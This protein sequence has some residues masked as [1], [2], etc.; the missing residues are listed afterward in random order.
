MTTNAQTSVSDVESSVDYSALI[1]AT[2]ELAT[3]MGIDA[4]PSRGSSWPIDVGQRSITAD[5][6]GATSGRIYLS[7]ADDDVQRLLDDPDGAADVVRDLVAAVGISPEEVS[8]APLRPSDDL[9]SVHVVARSDDRIVAFGVTIDPD[10]ALAGSANQSMASSFEPS[11]LSATGTTAG[12]AGTM[13][14]PISLLSDVDMQVTVE[15]GRTKLPVRELLSLQP[16]MVVELDRQAGEPIDVLVNGR[17]L[18]RG[19]VVVL[20]EQF[21]L[22]I[23]EIVSATTGEK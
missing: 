14:A 22:R 7:L 2:R 1:E 15:L 3:S 23:T 10:P 12:G 17:L 6:S 9:P 4:E 11:P 16:G 13:G 8:T 20:D 5:F 21:A 18:A 19:E